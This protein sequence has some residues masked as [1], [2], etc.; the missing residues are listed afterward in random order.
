[1]QTATLSQTGT[2]A[3]FAAKAS[4]A[5]A[6]LKELASEKRLMILCALMD[7]KE[8]S[9]TEITSRIDLSQS[10]LSQHLARLREQGIVAYRRD[11]TTLFYS[12]T[13]GNIGRILKTLKS[14]YC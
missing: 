7:D 2:M 8:M 1:M 13:D 4:E 12:V 14:I 3:S 10:A 6:L 5:A 11:G 9:V